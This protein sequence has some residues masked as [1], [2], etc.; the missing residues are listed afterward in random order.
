MKYNDQRDI[1]FY[2]S[3]LNKRKLS[4][5]P[6]TSWFAETQDLDHKPLNTILAPSSH[7]HRV[8]LFHGRCC[9]TT[10]GRTKRWEMH[11]RRGVGRRIAARERL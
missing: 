8:L 6:C 7:F 9:T 1:N 5:L 3:R 2:H 4:I 10:V 11:C